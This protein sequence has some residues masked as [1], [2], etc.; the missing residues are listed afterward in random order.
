MQ[1]ALGADFTDLNWSAQP[2]SDDLAT[3]HGLP[4]FPCISFAPMVHTIARRADALEG[5]LHGRRLRGPRSQEYFLRTAD[6]HRLDIDI[7]PAVDGASY[8][9]PLSRAMAALTRHAVC[10]EAR[11]SSARRA[12]RRIA[13]VEI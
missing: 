2:S 4:S 3:D 13:V 1:E 6:T 10:Y 8:R 5:V 9:L 11:S 12:V 7:D